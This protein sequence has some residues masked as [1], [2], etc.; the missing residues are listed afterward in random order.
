MSSVM[1]SCREVCFISVDGDVRRRSEG[2]A[3]WTVCTVAC[4]RMIGEESTA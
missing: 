3:L 1:A 4:N 2:D